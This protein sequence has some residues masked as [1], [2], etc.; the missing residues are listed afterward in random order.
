MPKDS[1]MLPQS[2]RTKKLYSSD[3]WNSAGDMLGGS[4]DTPLP[5]QS[6]KP[7]KTPLGMGGRTIGPVS[8]P[9]TGTVKQPFTL[10]PPIDQFQDSQPPTG[11]VGVQLPGGDDITGNGKTG[12]PIDGPQQRQV[13]QPT[14]SDWERF[15]FWDPGQNY[16]SMGWDPNYQVTVPSTGTEEQVAAV[17]FLNFF[18]SIVPYLGPADIGNYSQQVNQALDSLDDKAAAEYF[19]GLAMGTSGLGMQGRDT[20]NLHDRDRLRE[21]RQTLNQN[22]GGSSSEVKDALE[23]EPALRQAMDLLDLIL[24]NE[25]TGSQGIWTDDRAMTRRERSQYQDKMDTY[26]SG[27]DENDPIGNL[28]MSILQPTTN[29]P[30]LNTYIKAPQSYNYGSTNSRYA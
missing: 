24:G 22:L 21:V 5:K 28:I 2:G 26:L 20:S 29:T 8:K 19:R 6:P 1:W 14:A 3:D 11:D 18:N 17:N 12:T 10:Y 23:M 15:S 7:T 13:T 16:Q 27:V 4:T 9:S 25:A 30:L